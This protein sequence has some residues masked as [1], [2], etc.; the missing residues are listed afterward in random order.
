MTRQLQHLLAHS[1]VL[2]VRGPLDRE[3][4]GVALDSRRVRRGDLFAALRGENF[5]GHQFIA[6][7]VDNGAAA[8]LSEE[9]EKVAKATVVRVADTRKA[10]AEVSDIF[11][12]SPSRK[13]KLAGVTG[14]NGKTTVAFLL[15]HL[16]GGGGRRS[17]L[18]G[19]VHYSI[20]DRIL[21]AERTTPEA[22][23]IQR[24][25]GEMVD[26]GCRS[27]IMEVSSHALVQ[28]RVHG[29]RFAAGI[30]TNLTQ[31]H[32]DYH[33][34]MK[35]YFEAKV[36]LFEQMAGWRERG[37]T[38][39]PVAVI[40][41][42]DRHGALL[43]D[44]FRNRLRIATF[45]FS[46]RAD[47][48]ASNL[49]METGGTSYQLDARGRSYL[50]R[51]P[52]IG[53]FNVYNSLA[54]LATASQIGGGLRN[55]VQGLAR[56]PQVPGR[57]QKVPAKRK[58]QVF[59]DYAHTPDALEKA[60][61]TLKELVRGRLLVVFGCGGDRDKAKRPLMGKAAARA[62]DLIILTNDNPRREDPEAILKEIKQGVGSRTCEVVPDRRQAIERVVELAA[63]GDMILV[64]G[65]GHEKV[66]EFAD[67]SV[68][69]DDYAEVLRA[70]DEHPITMETS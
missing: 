42:D 7:A 31:D 52:L 15:Q 17:G 40:N 35:A 70:L 55:A 68:P 25:L 21:P 10:L 54:A 53:R 29:V 56:A 45:G 65:K 57:L 37:E 47:F 24:M 50:V 9:E 22:C 61:Q 28:H 67:H 62:A 2:Q 44:R 18:I 23:D 12:D 4:T 13:L 59:I 32:L 38:E 33:S 64:A 69:F 3:I 51:V 48:R 19:T 34:T 46:A 58:F 41:L 16:L 36:L 26:A 43:A 20:G 6:Q 63:D 11:Y 5:D 39:E 1:E 27:A 14:T 8:I 66:Q 60:L 30:F 49:H